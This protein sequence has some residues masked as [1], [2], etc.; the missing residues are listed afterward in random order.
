MKQN[1]YPLW[2]LTSLIFMVMLAGAC[3]SPQRQMVIGVSQCSEDIWREK[4]NEEL[5][6]SAFLYDN[7]ELKFAAAH[8]EDRLQSAQIDSFIRAKVDLLIVSPNQMHTISPIIS[9]ARRQGIPVI[10]FDRK[11]DSHDYTAFYGC[12]QLCRRKN[13]GRIYG[14]ATERSWYCHGNSRSGGFFACHSPS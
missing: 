14:S 10:L 3:H 2:F 4:L 6:T 5:R 8:D 13:H 12:R 1:Q 9:K 7:V 11:T